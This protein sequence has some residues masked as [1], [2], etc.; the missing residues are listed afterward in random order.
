M[1]PMGRPRVVPQLH[2]NSDGLELFVRRGWRNRS[3][4][5]AGRRGHLEATGELSHLLGVVSLPE[6]HTYSHKLT[7]PASSLVM[8]QSERQ[9]G[10]RDRS[11]SPLAIQVTQR[12]VAGDELS[13][14]PS[15]VLSR[16]RPITRP[17]P[18]ATTGADCALVC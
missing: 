17:R 16:F 2:S 15:F 6:Q 1:A 14:W 18:S 5:L 13:P 12:E 3:C 11:I 9:T 8:E 7:R 10:A 4:E